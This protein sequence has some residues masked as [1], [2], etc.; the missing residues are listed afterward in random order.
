M[1]KQQPDSIASRI[2]KLDVYEAGC[3]FTPKQIALRLKVPTNLATSAI[4]AMADRNEL[5]KAGD[6]R[7]YRPKRHWI[8]SIKFA[9]ASDS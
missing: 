1:A 6:G 3:I 4:V 5:Y 8:H 2:Q 9:N 7:Y